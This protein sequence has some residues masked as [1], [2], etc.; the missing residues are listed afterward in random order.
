MF[1]ICFPILPEP[2]YMLGI[3]WDILL[4]I[5]IQD[6]KR[7]KVL[8]YCIPWDMMPMD[9]QL[10]NMPSKQASILQLR[11]KTILRG[12]VSNSIK[13]VF[14]M[15][16]TEKLEPAIPPITNGLNGHSFNCLN[17]GTIKR[18]IKLNTLII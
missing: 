2:D 7:F 17:T 11:P 9:Y 10:N 6:T 13:L 3:H 15:I 4:P 5:S 8:M 14:H 12:I 1:L 16:G 18:V